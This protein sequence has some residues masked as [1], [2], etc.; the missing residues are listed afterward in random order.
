MLLQRFQNLIGWEGASVSLFLWGVGGSE[1]LHWVDY[2]VLGDSEPDKM[3]WLSSSLTLTNNI[4]YSHLLVPSLHVLYTL[5]CFF[6][7][8]IGGRVQLHD[9][10]LLSLIAWKFGTCLAER[11][12]QRDR[13]KEETDN[14]INKVGGIRH[15]GDV[16]G[17]AAQSCRQDTTCS[18]DVFTEGSHESR[19]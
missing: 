9:V 10:M 15:D 11:E 8:R 19:C 2:M 14:T 17:V 4:A 3:L 6:L 18:F 16:C 12:E 7:S 5:H 1:L 13:C